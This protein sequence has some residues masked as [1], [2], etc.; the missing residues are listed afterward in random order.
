M[1][2]LFKKMND[3]MNNDFKYATT[4]IKNAPEEQK[5]YWEPI[6]PTTTTVT[7]TTRTVTPTTTTVTPTTTTVTAT[8]EKD[9]DT[10]WD[11]LDD[12]VE[13][14]DYKI[15]YKYIIGGVLLMVLLMK[16]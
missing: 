11:F 16:K 2:I 12:A 13:I 7:P 9:K 1:D 10:T 15:K 8:A 6:T 3:Q 5:T 14:G 4:V